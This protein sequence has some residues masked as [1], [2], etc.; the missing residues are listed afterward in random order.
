MDCILF[1]YILV[2]LLYLQRIRNEKREEDYL[3][4]DK[5]MRIRGVMAMGIV[6]HHMSEI[7][8]AGRVF[9][10]LQ[11]MGYLLVSLFFFFSGYGLMASYRQKG[12]KY[13]QQF[14]KNKILYIFLIYLWI[15]VAYAIV[16]F[17]M[18]IEMTPRIFAISFINGSPVA[19]Y[20]WYI[21]VQLLL[22]IVFW[23]AF[24]IKRVSNKIKILIV[25]MLEVI[26]AVIFHQLSYSVIWY[27]SNFAFVVGI[28]WAEEKEQIDLFVDKHWFLSEVVAL[29]SFALFSGLPLIANKFW[30]MDEEVRL[31]CRIISS[32]VFVLFVIILMKKFTFKEG[33]WDFLGEISMEI[34]LVHGLIIILLKKITSNNIIWTILTIILSIALAC[35]VNWINNCIGRIVIKKKTKR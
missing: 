15:S 35:V 4:R 14:W 21:I 1:F 7:T 2:M 13:L 34:Y 29:G 6:L 10:L 25:L 26:M 17:L 27:M 30:G 23:G 5:A 11:H 16:K 24:S 19:N 33:V 22:Y 28:W 31:V 3:S 20:S 8:M 18:G 32:T 12:T 9:P